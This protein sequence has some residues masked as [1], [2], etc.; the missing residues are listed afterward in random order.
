MCWSIFFNK[1]TG[2]RPETSLKKEIPTHVFSCKFCEIFKSTF[3]TE[4]FRVTVFES[5]QF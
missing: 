2:W 5:T 4:H 1:V 3:L